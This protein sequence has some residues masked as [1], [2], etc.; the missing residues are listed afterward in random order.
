MAGEDP[1][2]RDRSLFECADVIHTVRWTRALSVRGAGHEFRAL[3]ENGVLIDLSQMRAVTID[4]DAHSPRSSGATMGD[5]IR[6]AQEHGLATATGTISGVVM[7]GLTW[8]WLWSLLNGAYGLVADNLLSAQVTADGH[9]VTA[10]AQERTDLFWGAAR[11][12]RQLWRCRFLE[13]RL[14]LLTTVLS[15]LLLYPLDQD[16]VTPF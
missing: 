15:S 2:S 8:G 11:R 16:S 3:R 9:L 14:H 6:A 13:Y 10:N 4:P 5:L 12:R 1:T 7:A